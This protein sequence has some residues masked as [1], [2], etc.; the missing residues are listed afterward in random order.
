MKYEIDTVNTELVITNSGEIV[1]F[2][3]MAYNKKKELFE[4][5]DPFKYVNAYLANVP[6]KLQD[7]LF[8]QLSVTQQEL[9]NLSGTVEMK[10]NRIKK[11]LVK[12]ASMIDSE[13]IEE[14]ID[15]YGDLPIP[16]SLKKEYTPADRDRNKTYLRHEYR[17]LLMLA[18]AGRL[19]VGVFGEY[20]ELYSD[21]SGKFKEHDLIRMLYGTWLRHHEA[22]YRLQ[23]YVEASIKQHNLGEQAIIGGL[24]SL[25]LVEFFLANIF[26]RRLSITPIDTNLQS[27]G[28]MAAVYKGYNTVKNNLSEK[29]SPLTDKTSTA[30]KN[31]RDEGSNWSMLE[32][33]KVTQ[34]VGF[35]DIAIHRHI[36][37]DVHTLLGHI[38]SSAPLAYLD[39][40]IKNIERRLSAIPL[41]EHA[42][43]LVQW[44][45]RTH[46]PPRLIYNLDKPDVMRLMA[47]TQVLLWHW[48]FEDL[49]LMITAV[50]D[51]ETLVSHSRVNL[52]KRQVKTNPMEE[53]N[54][55]FPY[56]KL[57]RTASR[58]RNPAHAAISKFNESMLACWL[59][60]NPPD[61]LKP[62]ARS[63]EVNRRGSL[64]PDNLI[65]Q[66]AEM[67]VFI[68]KRNTQ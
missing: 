9:K 3:L 43:L 42:V 29:F 30:K 44:V 11:Q 53:F 68:E 40:S 22:M 57:T 17:G 33:Y 46:I 6:A 60:N 58:D 13:D 41:Q 54:N 15:A 34:Q 62:H 31:S 12:L 59:K 48:E 2:S 67:L 37:H 28:L 63:V 45:L 7:R 14:W 61:Y 26:I 56:H 55:A 10:Y 64:A 35:D 66:L 18:I 50:T 25:E 16:S 47:L 49:A 4:D 32:L 51:R 5:D 27:G 38:D 8:E 19:M 36:A 23:R 21:V 20:M 39:D 1:R 52:P 24:S 65:T